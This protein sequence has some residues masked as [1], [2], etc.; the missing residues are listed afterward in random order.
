MLLGLFWESAPAGMLA[1]SPSWPARARPWCAE[2]AFVSGSADDERIMRFLELAGLVS[3]TGALR[4]Q[5]R[6]R[7]WPQVVAGQQSHYHL[8]AQDWGKQWVCILAVGATD[9]VQAVRICA[10]A[11]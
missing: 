11:L 8:W 10:L 4:S 9:G 6:L 1:R 2:D 7:A 5:T 3:G